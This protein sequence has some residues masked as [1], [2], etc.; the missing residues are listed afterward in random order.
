MS[1]NNKY[2][3]NGY[4]EAKIDLGTGV[5]PPN[6]Q[7]I[8]QIVLG[9]IMLEASIVPD[10]VMAAITEDL[11]YNPKYVLIA[12]AIKEMYQAGDPIDLL[13]VTKRIKEHGNL[14]EVGGH[15][16]I[17]VMM[18]RVT[19]SANI[20][21]HLKL[22]EQS[23]IARKLITI[24]GNT[25]KRCMDPSEDIFD[26]YA[27]HQNAVEKSIKDVLKFDVKSVSEIHT[28]I[29][30]EQMNVL[31]KGL[32]SG[33]IS[34]FNAVDR[35]TNG[36]QSSDLIIIAGRPGM[37]KTAAAVAMIMN[38]ALDANIPTAIFS[39]EM[40]SNQ[41]VGRMQSSLSNIMVGKIIR[42]QLDKGE[43]D[44]LVRTADVLNKAPIFV[45]DTP[46]ISLVELKGKVR[47][48]VRENGVRLVVIDYLQLMRS[49]LNIQ[50]REQEI[51]EISR[52]LKALAKE[53]NIPI[54]ALSQLSRN[55]ESRSDKK[56]L[57][58]DLRES[59][60]IE[61]DADMVIFCYRPEY[62]QIN[63]YEID[64]NIMPTKGLFMFII[65]KHRNG[66]IGEIKL[67]FRHEQTKVVNYEDVNGG[68]EM[69]IE[70]NNF[71]PN[72]SFLMPSTKVHPDNDMPF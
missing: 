4:Q 1:N 8:E 64:G 16:A 18:D 43:V 39:L 15:Y 53:C 40:S 59:G 10:K 42:K 37:G 52:G 31:N 50:N 58:Q 22:L 12:K 66:E 51:A 21:F 33:V 5:V 26:V 36:W 62:Y 46:S 72:T 63:E 54:I 56:P 41:I 71:E 67:G 17:S 45:D 61:Q 2:Q 20:E 3:K 14:E 57:L 24:S 48:M 55:V 30:K 13:T 34:G 69:Q 19:S 27:Y 25:I 9:A 6:V 60:Q 7:D 49:G 29:I 38:P 11:F 70:R 68:L 65:A 44:V 32:K 23:A 35:I 47:K 28:D